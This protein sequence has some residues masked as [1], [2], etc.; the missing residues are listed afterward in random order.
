MEIDLGGPSLRQGGVLLLIWHFPYDSL[1]TTGVGCFSTFSSPRT[2]WQAI[3]RGFRDFQTP[4]PYIWSV[5]EMKKTNA[6]GGRSIR[7]HF[8]IGVFTALSD[9]R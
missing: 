5:Y 1:P 4:V 7:L 3:F 8:Q 9:R 2:V 6:S